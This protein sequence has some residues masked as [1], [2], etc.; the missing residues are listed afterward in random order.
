[1]LASNLARSRLLA[2]AIF[3]L[4]LSS[5]PTPR[6]ATAYWVF[7]LRSSRAGHGPSD[8]VVGTL[9]LSSNESIKAQR[10]AGTFSLGALGPP[11]APDPCLKVTGE[12]ALFRRRD[13]LQIDFTPLASDCGL[14]AEGVVR[15]DTVSWIWYQPRFT[16]DAARGPFLMW[17]GRGSAGG[18]RKVAPAPPRAWGEFLRWPT[19]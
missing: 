7:E 13:S 18:P 14:V 5:A 9:E 6:H 1:M 12:S 16:G 19:Y 8:K 10:A 3:A 2:S 11:L 15:P 4:T 17:R